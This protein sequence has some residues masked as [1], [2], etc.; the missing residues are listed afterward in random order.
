MDRS[1]RTG[2]RGFCG[3]IDSPLEIRAKNRSKNKLVRK[4]NVTRA[5]G[6]CFLRVMGSWVVLTMHY[7]GIT[8]KCP[9]CH[10]LLIILKSKLS[11]SLRKGRNCVFSSLLGKGEEKAIPEVQESPDTELVL[12]KI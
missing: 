6:I 9:V 12:G 2:G 7:S 5:H 3:T 4:N 11:P 10:L 1:A 8:D